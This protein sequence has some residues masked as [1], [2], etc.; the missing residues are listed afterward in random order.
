MMKNC[1]K[2]LPKNIL[3]MLFVRQL[4]DIWL[5][6]L[7]KKRVFSQEIGNFL[8]TGYAEKQPTLHQ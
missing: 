8:Q 7:S 6:S 1:A 3:K 5:I 4:S 2:T